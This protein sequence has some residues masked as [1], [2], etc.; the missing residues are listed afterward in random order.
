MQVV[1]Q[2]IQG[3]MGEILVRQKTGEEIELGDLFVVDTEDGY[4]I[5]QAYDLKYASQ[6]GDKSRELISGLN[7]EGRGQGLEFMDPE[8]SNYIV[9]SLK[10][11]LTVSHNKVKISKKLPQFFSNVRRITQKDLRFLERP[12]FPLY[13][14]TMRSGSQDLDIDII[15]N[16]KNVLTHHVLVPA[17]TGSGKS[18]LCKVLAWSVLDK[19][20]CGMLILDPH[21]EYYGRHSRGLKDHPNADKLVYY[22]TKKPVP[23]S[24]TMTINVRQI[25]PW[26]FQGVL[27]LSSAQQDAIYAFYKKNE[28][29]WI[30]DILAGHE[31]LGVKE[32]TIGVLQRKLNIMGISL[33][34]DEIVCEGIFDST[35]GE[36]VLDDIV[37]E[38]ENGKTVIIDTSNL[39]NELE[40]LIGSM[41]AS[42]CLNKYKHYKTLGELE[43][44]PVISIVIEEAPRVL[45][46]EVLKS[47]GNIFSTIAREGRK[48]KVG[49]VAITQLPSMIPR[50]ILANMS[51]KIILSL[52]LVQERE[53]VI[54]SASQDLSKDDRNIA[55]LDVGEAIVTSNFTKFAVPLKVPLF[56]DI[57]KRQSEDKKRIFSGMD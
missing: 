27:E 47:G 35:A 14:G 10:T 8:L 54:Q 42:K 34:K 25:K 9:A 16:G 29:G 19:D 28:K 20:Y 31:P 56:E 30:Y 11:L 13:L 41:V 33:E 49:L 3:G 23:G 32:D 4:I 44:K 22:T 38:L 43:D 12:D 50:E 17:S 48:F 55:S 1:G 2:V 5:L 18:N 39:S 36:T 40:L 24:R 46:K 37:N 26:H 6:I 7:L 52:E 21:D 57:V 53:S 45:G 51:T 15:L